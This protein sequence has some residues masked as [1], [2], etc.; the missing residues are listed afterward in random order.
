MMTVMSRAIARAKLAYEVAAASS[1][2][3]SVRRDRL[4][5]LGPEKMHRLEG[6]L[7]AALRG[8]V[9]GD[10]LEF[11]VALGGSG[12]VLSKHA[13]RHGRSFHGFDVFGMIP[14]PTDNDDEGVKRR[15][16]VIASGQSEGIAGDIY[17]G[18]RDDLLGDVKNAFACYGI[19]VDG[20]SV[21]LHKGLF[22]ETW[23]R[24]T[25]SSIAFAHI[26]CDWYDP[27][28]FCLENVARK[29]SPGG[30][31][32]LDDYHDYGSCKRAT[33]EFLA[34]NPHFTFKDGK[35]VILQRG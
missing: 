14:P 26:D 23:P 12:I 34:R 17:Y 31:I 8:G 2:A 15:Y 29:L 20:R 25:G 9:P 11:G 27:V 33:D 16:E 35:N 13:L 24:Y 6:S 7:R 22:E 19:A 5:Y 32:V 1:T 21:Q 10:V 18:Y 4:T 30:I 28:R 3:R